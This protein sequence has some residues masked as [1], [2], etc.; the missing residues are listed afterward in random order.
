MYFLHHPPTYH[1]KDHSFTTHTHH[2]QHH[3]LLLLTYHHTHHTSTLHP[4][5]YHSNPLKASHHN[6]TKFYHYHFNPIR[7]LT[8]L[9][10]NNPNYPSRTLYLNLML[11]YNVRIS[12]LKASVASMMSTNNKVFPLLLL[13]KIKQIFIQN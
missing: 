6:Q 10:L 7:S 1:I 2:N 9:I 3:T 8:T 11:T 12:R 4:S 5:I 13:K